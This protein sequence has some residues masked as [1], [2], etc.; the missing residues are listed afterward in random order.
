MERTDKKQ[1]RKL[2]FELQK[3]QR[4][5]FDKGFNVE[6][7]TRDT[8]KE[9]PWIVGYVNK[10]GTNFCDGVDGRDFIHF[11]LYPFFNFEENFETIN[12]IQKF[13]SNEN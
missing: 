8:D 3:I 12:K 11:S 7:S 6:I 13:I 2:L 5:A 9:E 4:N 10:E 1:M